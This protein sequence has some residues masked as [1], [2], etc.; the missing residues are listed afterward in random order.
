MQIHPYLSF[1]GRTEEAIAFYKKALGAEVQMMMRFKDAP[2][3]GECPG[4]VKPPPDKIMHASLMI[5]ESM[6]MMSDGECKGTVNFS[7][8]ALSIDG[9]DDAQ[10]EKL[11][12][13]LSDGGNAIVPLMKTFFSSKFGMVIDRFGVTWMVLTAMEK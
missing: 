6:V 3:G 4:N 13:A 2:E 11:Y 7:G 1:E 5:G 8:I 9:K 12:A 10:T